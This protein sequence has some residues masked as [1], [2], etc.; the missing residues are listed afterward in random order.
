MV[1]SSNKSTRIERAYLGQNL[2]LVTTLYILMKQIRSDPYPSLGSFLTIY[3]W[4]FLTSLLNNPFNNVLFLS[5]NGHQVDLWQSFSN[6]IQLLCHF[7]TSLLNHFHTSL[8]KS[9][10]NW[11]FKKDGMQMLTNNH[12]K[13]QLK[14]KATFGV[15][16]S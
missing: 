12:P 15:Y 10:S 1:C 16:K 7:Q 2:K 6:Y 4:P 8:I 5:R 13:N 11:W 3:L 14:D 9:F